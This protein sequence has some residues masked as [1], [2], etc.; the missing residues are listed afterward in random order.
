MTDYLLLQNPGHNRV[1]YNYAG[2]L[3]VA[4]LKIAAQKFDTKCINVG[5]EQIEGVRYIILKTENELSEKDMQILSRLSFVFAVYERIIFENQNLFK[6]IPKASY[7]YI[8]EKI[9]TILKYSGKTNELFTKMMINI[10]LLSSNFDHKSK[11]KLLDPVAGRGTT[12]F[13]GI[14]YGFDVF[15]IETDA[16]SV[17][18]STV[19]FKKYIE[20]EKL[21]HSF[22]KRQIFGKNK[23][24]AVYINEFEFSKTKYDFKTSQKRKKF[25]IIE[26]STQEAANYFKNETFEIIVGDLPYGIAHGNSTGKNTISITRNPSELL[27]ASLPSWYKVLKKGGVIVVAWNVFVASKHKISKIFTENGFDVLSEKNPDK[28]EHLVDNSIKRDIIVAKKY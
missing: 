13:E 26:G 18:D 14:V 20:K 21:K 16:K 5:I 19:F 15:G 22:I 8:D 11:I 25:G 4:E 1:Y 6:P 24:E 10:A 23:S 12:L 17:Q 27:S 3:A 7:Y 28:F 9:S 2:N